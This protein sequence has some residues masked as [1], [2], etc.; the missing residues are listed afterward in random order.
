MK[1]DTA[2]KFNVLSLA[3]GVLGLLCLAIPWL[4]YTVTVPNAVVHQPLYLEDCPTVLWGVRLVFAPLAFFLGAALA[5]VTPFGGVVMSAGM[6]D[7]YL[8][9]NSSIKTAYTKGLDPSYSYSW[10]PA[11]YV[12]VIA[13]VIASVS[14][15]LP[16]G[17]SYS[18][19]RASWANDTESILDRILVWRRDSGDGMRGM[20]HWSREPIRSLQINV[21][22]VMAAV[23]VIMSIVL[24]WANGYAPA[25]ENTPLQSSKN[26]Y[27]LNPVPPIG[28]QLLVLPMTA[29]IL[30]AIVSLFSPL[31]GFLVVAGGTVEF[32]RL[33]PS[34]NWFWHFSVGPGFYLGMSAAI[35]ILVSLAIP[36]TLERSKHVLAL[37]FRKQP[38]RKRLL[39]WQ[40]MRGV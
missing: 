14:I 34:V 30:G 8:A 38:L 6:L 1:S 21:L 22:C 11:F 40:V 29:V 17:L 36:I 7:L 37:S 32:F 3:G 4:I 16:I 33:L 26:L 2:I 13:T 39:T 24:P 25:Y 15:F 28:D 9:A 18:H 23:I 12:G 10:G 35:L 31:G 19:G 27:P 5:L 20:S